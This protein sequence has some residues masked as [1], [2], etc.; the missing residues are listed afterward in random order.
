V[1]LRRPCRSISIGY[2]SDRS[3][4]ACT[5][6]TTASQ[7]GTTQPTLTAGG[8]WYKYSAAADQGL[9]RGVSFAQPAD[10][11]IAIDNI[12]LNYDT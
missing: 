5:V 2:F 11:Y 7:D 10:G 6:Y 1:A 3:D 9:V 8:G 12:T 4:V